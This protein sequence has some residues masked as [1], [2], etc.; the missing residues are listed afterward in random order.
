M[1][2][3]RR[4][5]L[6]VSDNDG[7]LTIKL[8]DLESAAKLVYAAMPPTPQTQY[9]LLSARASCEVWVKHENHTPLG[10]F[11]VRGGLVYMDWL[12]REHP[13]VGGVVTATRGNHGQ[14]V[15]FAARKNGLSA[16][17]FVPLG[18]SREK[19][20]AMVALGG[21]LMEHGHDFQAASEASMAYAQARG[22]HH[23][24]SYSPFLVAG[25][26]TYSME[27]LRAHPDLM[28]I[29][30]PIGLGS[31][32]SGAIAA[33]DAL[34][35]KTEII[36]VVS[37]NAPAYALSFRSGLPTATESANT[38]A[39]GVAC[40]VPNPGAVEYICKGAADVITVS[41][42]EIKTAM[43]A[44]YTDTHNL[45]EG[46]GAVPLAGLLKQRDLRQGQK[47]AVVLSGSNID[48]DQYR[49]VLSE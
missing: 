38:M 24:P 14:S 12:K 35:L 2:T 39:D 41:E 6:R 28:A 29:Y 33:R 9:P 43:R 36:G 8:A 44:Y 22:L 23:M 42:A 48:L 34:H 7:M 16:T 19:N 27:L 18:N 21:E 49:A 20:A 15:A 45:A 3:D 40:R 47:V 31:G 4:R 10:A 26:A 17:I 1:D 37:E 5:E 13:D 46:A 30:V 11:K 32:I 25:V